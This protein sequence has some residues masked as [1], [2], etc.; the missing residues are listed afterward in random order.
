MPEDPHR[1]DGQ[2]P[3][4]TPS[5]SEVMARASIVTHRSTPTS[6]AAVLNP[7]PASSPKARLSPSRRK[8]R[9]RRKNYKVSSLRGPEHVSP[10]QEQAAA[11]LYQIADACP[12]LVGSWIKKNELRDWYFELADLEGWEV[13]GWIGVAKALKEWTT[14]R[15]I[16]RNGEKLTCYKVVAISKLLKRRAALLSRQTTS[17]T[18]TRGPA[19]DATA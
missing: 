8:P 7:V 12:Q 5:A 3:T 1:D 11:L 6:E 19:P 9:R 2:P 15:R 18:T 4:L 14:S 10:A 17:V 13:Q 16:T